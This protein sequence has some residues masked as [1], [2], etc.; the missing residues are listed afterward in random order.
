[1]NTRTLGLLKLAGCGIV[2]AVI[3][4]TVLKNGLG[5]PTH[6]GPFKMILIALPGAFGLAG[7]LEL[8]TGIRFQDISSA[9][10]SLAGWQRGVLGTLI[11]IAAFFLMMVGIVI[12]A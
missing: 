2:Y 10:D 7:L 1:M 5:D 4:S 11:V 6:G 8:A 9:W 12:F 3:F